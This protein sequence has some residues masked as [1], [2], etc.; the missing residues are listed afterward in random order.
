MVEESQGEFDAK[1][2]AAETIIKQTIELIFNPLMIR[3]RCG[4]RKSGPHVD[5]KVL[6]TAGGLMEGCESSGIL[7][8]RK[9]GFQEVRPEADQKICPI[10]SIGRDPIASRNG[11]VCFAKS[12]VGKRFIDAVTL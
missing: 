11:M 2:I 10:Y 7:H 8:R 4:R 6:A 5:K 12:F 3:T 1:N 9:P